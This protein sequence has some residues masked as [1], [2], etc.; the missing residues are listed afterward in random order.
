MAKNKGRATCAGR[1]RKGVHPLKYN[2]RLEKVT[3]GLGRWEVSHS[4]PTR[5]SRRT[6]RS[7]SLL[8]K[9]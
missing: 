3:I 1:L 2:R 4:L 8:G 5:K 6:L 9:T 7:P